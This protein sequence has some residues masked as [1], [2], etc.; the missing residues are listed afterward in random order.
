MILFHSFCL[1]DGAEIAIN[2][3]AESDTKMTGVAVAPDG[4]IPLTLT[5][6]EPKNR[7]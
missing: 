3:K 2:L 1:L 5:K 6:E 4:E 7:I